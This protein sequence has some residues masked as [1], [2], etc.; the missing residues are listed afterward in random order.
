MGAE[1]VSVS[2]S[3]LWRFLDDA[4]D[5]L[6]TD[7]RQLFESYW[8]GF[9]QL[10]AELESKSIEASLSPIIETVPVFLTERWDRYVMDESS[11]DYLQKAETLTL[12]VSAPARL[13][14]ET[15]LYDTL[16]LGAA[17][18]QLM[19]QESMEFFDGSIRQL[20]YGELVANTVSV[21][22]GSLEFTS[23]YDY[24][25]NLVDGSV[26]ALDGGRLPVDQVVL[27][28]YAH[29]AY[30]RGLDYEIDE[31]RAEV[32]VLDGS[33]IA[34]G[35][36]V[37]ATYTYNATATVP[38]Q[39]ASGVIGGELTSLVDVSCDF[40]ALLP[41]RTLT[42]L[43]GP[44]QGSYAVVGIVGANELEVSPPFPAAQADGGVAYSIDAFPHG[45]RISQNIVSIPTLQDLI[46]EPNLVL[47]EGVD[48]VIARGILASRAAFPM[49]T[50]GPTEDRRRA[51]WAERTLV[52]RETPY[53]NFGVLIDFYRAN[54]TAYKQALQGLWYTFWTGST[55]ENLRR[56]LHILLG[57]PYARSAGAVVS[58]V[59]PTA[60]AS[61]TVQI[62]DARG[63]V[64]SYTLPSALEPTVGLGQSVGRFAPLCTG[65]TIIDRN[66]EPGFVANRLG[67]AGIARFL[68]SKASRGPGDTD[69]TKALQLLEHHLFVPQILTDALTSL[70]NV[71][72]LLTFL[73]NM[74]PKW[75]ELVF[76]F[77]I[78][79]EE[80]VSLDA[81]DETIDAAVT[82]DASTTVGSNESNRAEADGAFL[83]S[84]ATGEIVVGSR[85]TGNFRDLGADF[86]ALD[87][88]AGD[89]VRIAGGG[90]H[91]WY[92]V[93]ARR[94]R[95]LLSLDLPDAMLVPAVG[96]SYV[97]VPEELLL[98]HD[99][100][101]L[102]RE[103]LA[104]AG[105]TLSAGTVLPI[106]TDAD[107]SR[108]A[109]LDLDALLLIDAGNPGHEVQPITAARADL[110]EL[111][112]A[113]PP[114]PGA[115]AHAVA[116]AVLVRRT[117]AGA[118]TDVFAI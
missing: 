71:Q 19:H 76:S 23:G 41:E 26:Q 39:S 110:G 57:L 80:R 43:A 7:D 75:T 82:I 29:A 11:C 46:D 98:G 106:K 66:S 69:E 65:V 8:R 36:R 92:R 1:A 85:A 108:L 77:L 87:V 88:D 118:V 114:V 83:L 52:D 58:L 86:A 4:W 62:Q 111:A 117:S 113:N 47:Q 34:D 112:V 49:M 16:V 90:Y 63:Q 27:V 10:G 35:T 42:I 25:V 95:S 24:V 100:V 20:R 55:P 53:R 64:L 44:N 48:Y 21:R 78:E 33:T 3:F 102:K 70:I 103:H 17:S 67:R 15:A 40:S 54:S 104:R 81:A 6:P 18:G 93:L 107:L 32:R 74:K 45:Q 91:G 56:G 13:G 50:I 105:Q 60:G 73:V 72:E 96:L 14:E 59:P 116:A 12:S 84:R 38:L 101:N 68:T 89:I 61:G 51:M 31:T 30:T 94:D 22:L 97:V 115:R 37:A 99:A 109:D 2:A 28:T 79:T 5:L 9:L